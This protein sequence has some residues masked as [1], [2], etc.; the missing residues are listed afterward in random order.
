M[1]TICEIHNKIDK[2]CT[3]KFYNMRRSPD[4]VEE[5]QD[6]ISDMERAFS[7]IEDLISEALKM[8]QRMEDWLRNRKDFMVDKGVE[9]EY[10]S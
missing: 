3:Q 7:D 2:I 4:T 1:K 6:V 10:Q 8:W 5:W 9:D